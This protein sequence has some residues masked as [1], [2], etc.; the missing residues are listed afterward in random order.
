[1]E[2]FVR[3]ALEAT[4]VGVG[5]GVVGVT[6]VFRSFLQEEAKINKLNENINNLSNDFKFILFNIYFGKFNYKL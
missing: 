2:S 5:V 4:G 1:M 6:E 3:S